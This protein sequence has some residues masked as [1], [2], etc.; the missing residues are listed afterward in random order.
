MVEALNETGLRGHGRRLQPHQRAQDPKSVLDKVVPGYYHR[1]DADGDVEI[2][3]VP[4][5][6]FG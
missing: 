6:S 2:A 4:G 1:L 5:T 3:D